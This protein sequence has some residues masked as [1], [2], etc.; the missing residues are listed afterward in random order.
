MEP[1]KISVMQEIHDLYR[2]GL[3][4][5][6]GEPLLRLE[7]ISLAKLTIHGLAFPLYNLMELGTLPSEDL[8]RT[9]QWMR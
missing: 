9:A 2:R 7:D 3:L 8:E 5:S 1:E 6:R 4:E